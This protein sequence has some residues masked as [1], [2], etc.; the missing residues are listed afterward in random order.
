MYAIFDS[1]FNCAV[2]A[3]IP[4]PLNPSTPDPAYAL[5]VSA[6]TTLTVAQKEPIVSVAK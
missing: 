5:I 3:A 6:S 1:G 2:V 4:S